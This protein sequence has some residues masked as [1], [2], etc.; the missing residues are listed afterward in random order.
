M[1]NL[2]EEYVTVFKTEIIAVFVTFCLHFFIIFI[3]FVYKSLV[4]VGWKC[5]YSMCCVVETV[6]RFGVE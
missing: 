1:C 4:Y 6:L 5:I 2:R 3:F